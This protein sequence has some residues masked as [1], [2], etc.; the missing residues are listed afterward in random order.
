MQ[1]KPN[2]LTKGEKLHRLVAYDLRVAKRIRNKKVNRKLKE[3]QFLFNYIMVWDQSSRI[4]TIT[5]FLDKYRIEIN[6]RWLLI[7]LIYEPKYKFLRIRP[8][9]M[10]ALYDDLYKPGRIDYRS[11]AESLVDET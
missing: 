9:K 3:V 1:I 10:R 11:V 2:I 4:T 7:D 6:G 8:W 5:V